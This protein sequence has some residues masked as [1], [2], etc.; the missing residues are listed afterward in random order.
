M[1]TELQEKNLITL[2]DDYKK[3]NKHSIIES[4]KKT[5]N[6]K[7]KFEESKK[8]YEESKKKYDNLIIK[9]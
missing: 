2:Y 5:I 7:N 6:L 9:D 1:S 4:L 8:K 3:K